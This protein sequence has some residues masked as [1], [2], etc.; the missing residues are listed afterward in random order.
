MFTVK[1]ETNGAAFRSEDTSTH[2]AS[3]TDHLDAAC[4]EVAMRLKE[5]AEKIEEGWRGGP[6]ID[7]NGHT[8]GTWELDLS[9]V[10]EEMG[11]M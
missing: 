7:T 9:A 10:D 5:I 4:G 11:L 3:R 6:V 8:V 1:F 2:T